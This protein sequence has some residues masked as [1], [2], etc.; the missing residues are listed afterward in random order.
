MSAKFV[1]SDAAKTGF[2]W[3]ISIARKKEKIGRYW[4]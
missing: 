1:R 4:Y 3:E 2:T